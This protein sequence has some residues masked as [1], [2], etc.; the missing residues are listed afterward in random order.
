MT[1]NTNSRTLKVSY[2]L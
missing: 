1:G 2:S